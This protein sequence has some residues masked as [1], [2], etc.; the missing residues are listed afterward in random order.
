MSAHDRGLHCPERDP[1]LGDDGYPSDRE[2]NRIRCWPMDGWAELL[3][4][5]EQRWRHVESGCWR[6]RGTHCLLSTAGWRGNE[7]LVQALSE[8]VLFWSACWVWS[9]RGGHY[10]LRLPSRAAPGADDGGYPLDAEPPPFGSSR[11]DG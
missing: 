6:Q 5:V 4:Y 7:S 8:N 10:A 11:E 9:G 1:V 3:A 2:L